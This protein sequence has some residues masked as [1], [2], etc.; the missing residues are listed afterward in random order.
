MNILLYASQQFS[1]KHSFVINAN[2][3]GKI[4][5]KALI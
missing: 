2:P 1:A 4:G 5:T 3:G